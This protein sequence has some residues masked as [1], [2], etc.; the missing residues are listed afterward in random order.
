MGNKMK[1]SQNLT[2]YKK[3]LNLYPKSYR[4]KYALSMLQTAEDMLDDAPSLVGR[5][6]VWTKLLVDVPLSAAKLQLQDTGQVL[7]QDT[8]VYVWRNSVIA[9]LLLLP[10]MLALIANGLDK[11]INNHTLY[12]S[13][14]WS[15]P[16][17]AFWVLRLP[18]LAFLIAAGS[19]VVYVLRRNSK[20]QSLWRRATDLRHA[21][22]LMLVTVL[23]FGVL[24]MLAFHD[25]GQC[26]LHRQNS[27]SAHVS[28]AWQC[29]VSNSSIK[30]LWR[31]EL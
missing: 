28:S 7:R 5:L 30:V 13:W 31:N 4:Q 14:L 1:K 3:L 21:W 10:F 25:S 20:K 16:V 9:G 6:G 27:L 24:F 29:A 22:T 23:A 18:E 26:V 11:V 12:N 15:T 8:P 2:V 19:Y 17:L